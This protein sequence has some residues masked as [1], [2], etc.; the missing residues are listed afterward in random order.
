MLLAIRSRLWLQLSLF[1]ALSLTGVIGGA[2]GLL[3]SGAVSPRVAFLLCLVGVIIE[4]GVTLNAGLAPLRQLANAAQAV[5]E[6]QP[7]KIRSSSPDEVGRVTQ[8]LRSLQISTQT[9]MA[10]MTSN[11]PGG[12]PDAARAYTESTAAFPVVTVGPAATSWW[13][14]AS[15]GGALAVGIV[16]GTLM[17]LSAAKPATAAIAT[18]TAI[19]SL[20]DAPRTALPTLARGVTG[21]S[22]IVGTS[23]PYSGGPRSLSEGMKLGLDTAF[24]EINAAGGV[25]G[26]QIKLVA[27]D[28]GYDEKRALET[29]RDLVENR[30]VF[31]LIGNVGTPTVKAIIPY[32]NANKILLFGPLTGSP[33]TRADPPDRYLI[34][35]RPSYLQETEQMIR[36]L[37]DAKRLS[38]RTIVV[39]AQNDA[40][41]DAGYAGA[42]QALKKKNY[43]GEPLRVGYDR[44]TVDVDDAVTR[45][46]AY[47]TANAKSGGV[48]AV[49]VVATAAASAAFTAK[50]SAISAI[51]LNVSFVDASQL[52]LEFKEHWPGVGNGVIVTQVVPH[53]DSGAT[54]V[55]RYREALHTFYPDK[56]PGF[57]SLEGYVVGSLFIEG[58]RR[59]GP[60]VDTERMIDALEKIKDLD[61]GMG[62]AYNF[63]ISDHQASK[64]VW[65]TVLTP[66]GF[67]PLDS[68]WTE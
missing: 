27:L 61:L 41:G 6:G 68:E 29:T 65:G 39:F 45:V 54:G 50:I 15:I 21:N 56:S 5:S 28:N 36:Y 33:V 59:A 12:D 23:A 35:V 66:T 42:V 3:I 46:L 17:S 22:V 8:A 16:G 67:K 18:P 53:Y 55:I 60:N 51:V 64:K 44:N 24:A 25:H 32:V 58:L 26:R 34:N 14:M 1:L 19:K 40:F 11:T 10:R 43:S 37:I 47:N 9:A 48:R 7:L 49:I 57:S 52:A 30:H 20:I 38:P 62:G 63:G 2:Y 13:R 4:I 31:G